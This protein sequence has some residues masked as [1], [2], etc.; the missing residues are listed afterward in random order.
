MA[1][2]KAANAAASTDHTG[3]VGSGTAP[4]CSAKRIHSHRP[5]TMPRGTPITTPTAAAMD[6]CQATAPGQLSLDETEDSEE[7][8]ISAAAP[9]RCRQRQS[10]GHHGS[11]GQGGGEQQRGSCPWTW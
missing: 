10:E 1:S 6:V 4:I 11:Q 7:G 8:Q 9:H 2:T 5:S 3:T